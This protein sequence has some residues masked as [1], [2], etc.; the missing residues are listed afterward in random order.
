MSTKISGLTERLQT[1][2]NGEEFF[3]IID[4][5]N[6]QY[7][8]YKIKLDTLFQSGQGYEKVTNLALTSDNN[9]QFVLTY[10][11]EDN[12]TN[13]L[14]IPKYFIEDNDVAFSHIDP[15]GYITSTQKISNNN[16]D[17]KLATAKSVDQ[18]I[19]HRLYGTGLYD[20]E[21]KAYFGDSS[22]S[23]SGTHVLADFRLNTEVAAD[24]AALKDGVSTRHDTLKKIE[25]EIDALNASNATKIGIDQV[26]TSHFKI[27]SSNLSTRLN[28]KDL[29][30]TTN[31]LNH[32]AVTR[33]KLAN[34]A[35]ETSK[36]KTGA[37]I[38]DKLATNAVETAK[39]KNDAVTPAK[40]SSGGPSWDD[41]TVSIPG[42][43]SVTA[44]V[45]TSGRFRSHATDF[46]LYNT[47]RSNGNV[48]NGRALVHGFSDELVI[49]YGGDYTGG[50]T[51][52]GVVTAPDLSVQKIKSNGD[53]TVVTKAYVDDADIRIRPLDSSRVSDDCIL[54]RHMSDNS[55]GTAEILDDS[56]TSAKIE[57]IGPQWDSNGSVTIQNDLDAN[58]LNFEIGNSASTSNNPTIVKLISSKS[59]NGF[60]AIKRNSGN[61][62]TLIFDNKGSGT[63]EFQINGS[64][65]F[66]VKSGRSTVHG[67]FTVTGGGT[68]TIAGSDFSNPAFLVG[69][70][71]NGIAIDNNEIYQKGHHMHI[72]VTAESQNIYFRS[73]LGGLLTIHGNGGNVWMRN[74]ITSNSGIFRQNYDN[75]RT[76]ILGGTTSDRGAN[77]ILYGIDNTSYPGYA[78]Y[79]AD[80]HTFRSN[81][82]SRTLLTIDSVANNVT[83]NYEGTS[84]KHLVTKGY[85]D[86]NTFPKITDVDDITNRLNSGFYQTKQA[87]TA[88]GWPE[89][90]ASWYH[91][92]SNTHSNTTNY[93]ALQFAAD[94]YKQKVFFRSTNNDG[95]QAWSELWHTNNMGSGS[96]LDADTVDGKHAADFATATHNHDSR[97]LRTGAAGTATKLIT[98]TGGLASTNIGT[99]PDKIGNIAIR[100]TGY[101][102]DKLESFIL[103]KTDAGFS[104]SKPDG[105]HNG[106]GVISLRTH[107]NSSINDLGYF[108]QL[109][110]DT[111]QNNLWIRSA[112][113]ST[114]FNSWNK[115]WH[116]GNHGSGSGLD[117]DKLAGVASTSYATKT[118]SD[119]R[120]IQKTGN[121]TLD[122]TLN[123]NKTNQGL[124]W[125]MN[126][127]GA[128]IRF[129]NTSDGDTNSRLEFN[130][131]DNY[132]EEFLF[133]HT[134]HNQ[135][136]FDWLRIGHNKLLHMGH[137][138]WHEG[139]D[140]ANSG[141]DADTVDGKHASD[142]AT[143]NHNH[144]D[145]YVKKGVT[146][147]P[148]DLSA[149]GPI[150]DTN[151][152]LT[153]NGSLTVGDNAG[154]G[155][156]TRKIVGVGD[157]LMLHGGSQTN[158]AKIELYS[159]NNSNLAKHIRL[160]GLTTQIYSQSN[161][162]LDIKSDGQI[163]APQQTKAR[164]NTNK[165]LTT[166]EWVLSEI[167]NVYPDDN[168]VL[169][170]DPEFVSGV[171]INGSLDDTDYTRYTGGQVPGAS[172]TFKK[173]GVNLLLK[174]NANG[175]SGV[176]FESEKDGT[177]I[178][179]GSDY[180]FIQYHAYG[181]GNLSGEQSDL[182]IG[183][184][185][186][187]YAQH[188]DKIIFDIP[189]KDHLK[190]II[191]ND[192]STEYKVWHEGND[193]TGSGLDA[194]TV[195]GIHA[196]SFF[197][198]GSTSQQNVKG[199]TRFDQGKRI[200]FGHTNQV[201]N[202]DGGISAGRHGSGLN[203]V[204]ART[205]TNEGRI[206]RT[207]GELITSG[208][209]KYW[210]SGNDGKDS[211]LDAGYLGGQKY[212]NYLLKTGKAADSSKL[213]G[214]AASDYVTKSNA[215]FIT[216][217]NTTPVI[218]S[219]HGRTR[220]SVKIG[221]TDQAC[222]FNY[223]NDEN[224]NS[225]V[226][227]FN[228]TDTEGEGGARANTGKV[229]FRSLKSY[230][231]NSDK[232]KGVGPHTI[233]G[234]IRDDRSGTTKDYKIWH[235]GNDGAN[236]GLDADKLDGI[237][238]SS[239]AKIN[240]R[241]PVSTPTSDSHAAT[242]KYVDDKVFDDAQTL[243][244]I[245][246]KAF[247]NNT[248]QEIP[249]GS[250]SSLPVGWYTIAYN[251]GDRAIARFGVRDVA[252]GRH[253]SIIFTASHTF[254]MD[255]SN[256]IT[257]THNSHYAN[258]PIKGIRIKEGSTYDGAALQIYI[259]N[260]SNNVKAYI[261]GDN[262][263]VSGW[264]KA[265][266]WVPDNTNPGISDERKNPSIE[267]RYQTSYY[268]S[269]GTT[270][271]NARIDDKS[272]WAPSGTS[273][274][275][276]AGV[277]IVP[278]PSQ[279]FDY[280]QLDLGAVKTVTG[281]E[282]RGRYDI[283]HW[284][285][286]Y[287][288]AYS[289]NGS[290]WTFA[291]QLGKTDYVFTGNSNRNSLVLRAFS[292]PVEARY[293]RI[294]PTAGNFNGW[295]VL[296]FGVRIDVWPEL[297]NIAADLD[298][299][300]SNGGIITTDEIYAGGTTDQYKVWHEGN[301]K[302]A[303]VTDKI[304]NG[305]VTTAKLSTG[306]PTWNSTSDLFVEGA[307]R[308][309]DTSGQGSVI[310]YTSISAERDANKI[311]TLK[312]NGDDE[313]EF[314]T[315][316]YDKHPRMIISKY[317]NITLPPRDDTPENLLPGHSKLHIEDKAVPLSF[318][319]TDETGAGSLWRMP[320]D[321]KVLRFDA[322]QDGT[323][324]TGYKEILTLGADGKIVAPNLLKE[325]IT[326]AKSLVTKEYV[327]NKLTSN[328]SNPS[329]S[330]N[331]A[332]TGRTTI[333]T[334]I[335]LQCQM[336][337]FDTSKTYTTSSI[338]RVDPNNN[339]TMIDVLNI[340]MTP[341]DSSSCFKI[342]AMIN[343][344]S[345]NSSENLVFRLYR[346]VGA[347]NWEHIGGYNPEHENKNSNTMGNMFGMA[348]A[349]Y[350]N[351][352]DSTMNNI[353]LQFIDDP[354][355]TSEVEYAVG[356]ITNT[357]TT[358]Y[359]N[360]VVSTR[361]HHSTYGSY[362]RASSNMIVT[363]LAGA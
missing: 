178:N 341:R 127:D 307:L 142:F 114:S 360:R 47:G 194:D 32:Q 4:S 61:S 67:G 111:N 248:S 349:F 209:H 99:T 357:S 273:N 133:S 333:R 338:D 33:D 148:S 227:E 233:E 359:L 260:A 287:Q 284:V 358:F 186:D 36:I 168:Y 222:T 239:F 126:T 140:G 303:I 332:I 90:T 48:H 267:N 286:K 251:N 275:V 244:G 247:Y 301:T 206:I 208:S 330:G 184:A 71:S 173:D 262:F 53:N 282:T 351:N 198:K 268:S 200:S 23:R 299:S 225:Y 58:G 278:Y 220:E 179:S 72:G 1:N 21:I 73:S 302:D 281:V 141:L 43:L 337:H 272:G 363:E 153:V 155:I 165:A 292:Q 122:G 92:L 26:N 154:E 289:S 121:Q 94:Y 129:H 125:G 42:A 110:L 316:W 197:D 112:N 300:N 193:G 350:D 160:R 117:A 271:N 87:D 242:K 103:S 120:Y 203:I 288:V 321:G 276:P 170:D 164:I 343:F 34:N 201:N 102:I 257:I 176:Y 195:D 269:G 78:Y 291:Q 177:R 11:K 297:T 310:P 182:V 98:F 361:K 309:G 347:G 253:Q 54:L 119:G 93:H 211:T 318:K 55:V 308:L 240:T 19:D 355:A 191:R 202:D 313:I 298:L 105:T 12:T 62:G 136:T 362:E 174:G 293:I 80:K 70:D 100:R 113:N 74:G 205:K 37:V 290:S 228:N 38:A 46:H 86:A 238:A 31:L 41:T 223:T 65:K 27:N 124:V 158:A 40:I 51:I 159:D 151:S 345:N 44:D 266:R 134:H 285:T 35:V 138:V 5:T 319:E 346:R 172:G 204:G 258:Q 214:T 311:D 207:W 183:V 336:A 221:L 75:Q 2:I 131:R 334:G 219:R 270:L 82:R 215:H 279:G 326:D 167:A 329:Y 89:S 9:T 325:N 13:V 3:P 335:A 236:S 199:D 79:D 145:I 259:A 15:A 77:V 226:F 115:I 6:S 243:D 25:V 22:T 255:A 348:T 229:W 216:T 305:A 50:V 295:P 17:D 280:A 64:K 96:G 143:S 344:E 190:V 20:D 356:F 265:T 231:D 162:A 123:F 10:T 217:N 235:S 152:N 323:T 277:T 59:T 224:W 146:I 181:I 166:K 185:N 135:G 218:I 108:T 88:N 213:G 196:S 161:L 252:S 132:D 237:H 352:E 128:S 354:G 63:H 85:V 157:S 249:S 322:S 312:L 91:M 104:G 274:L 95:K 97:Y 304:K 306:A 210:H 171:I 56:I 314:S 169:R 24:F 18:H 317:G 245:D 283:D 212:D 353:K 150:W 106:F 230:I 39:I 149:G 130:T 107:A 81:N 66:E 83:L 144:D 68:T 188:E 60:A 137:K 250:S 294:Y 187:G 8:T 264:I 52:K 139:N 57:N 101:N 147:T 84:A 328:V 320:L 28:I 69:S 331:Q 163:V 234:Y 189:N 14:T 232:S 315:L 180:G 192:T 246:S 30:I 340:K 327:D 116:D 49:N 254:G 261:L 342:E 324:F 256:N 45:T 118:Y 16:S 339:P 76:L 29:G 7:H 263:Q 296:R 156:T 109:G 175:V 241:I